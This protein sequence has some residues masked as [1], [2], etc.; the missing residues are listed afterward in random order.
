[1]RSQHAQNHCPRPV[2]SPPLEILPKPHAQKPA[3]NRPARQA[4]FYAPE[5]MKA[6]VAA[7][8][9]EEAVVDLPD[10]SS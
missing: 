5:G 9:G 3:R 1:M 8:A 4:K 7:R 2:Q 10:N 6:F